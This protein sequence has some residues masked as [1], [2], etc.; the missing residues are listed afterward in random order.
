MKRWFW[1]LALLLGACSSGPS[2]DE[3]KRLVQA[4]LQAELGSSL[5]EPVE[6]AIVEKEE[7]QEGLYRVAVRYQLHFMKDFAE[8][9]T[10]SND[11]LVYDGNGKFHQDLPLMTLESRYGEFKAGERRSQESTL[12]VVHTEQGWRLAEPVAAPPSP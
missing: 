1:L 12:W 6:L 9:D 8:L 10:A 2:E 4:H 7:T 5:V 11:D 3:V